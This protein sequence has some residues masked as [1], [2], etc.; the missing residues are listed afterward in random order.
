MAREVAIWLTLLMATFC[1]EAIA[2]FHIAGL[3]RQNVSKETRS[4]Q[5]CCGCPKVVVVALIAVMASL[6]K[7]LSGFA[8]RRAETLWVLSGLISSHQSVV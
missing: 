2:N 1:Y 8:L 4:C 6:G 3:S 5:R 7:A